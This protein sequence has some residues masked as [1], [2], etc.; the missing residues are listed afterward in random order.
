[1]GES[2]KLVLSILVLAATAFGETPA[3]PADHAEQGLKRK[4]ALAQGVGPTG[5]IEVGDFQDLISPYFFGHYGIAGLQ[6]GEIAATAVAA[7][8]LKAALLAQN[9]QAADMSIAQLGQIFRA[10]PGL[11]NFAR[12]PQ[13]EIPSILAVNAEWAI[14]LG[15]APGCLVKKDGVV[16]V[17]RDANLIPLTGCP[18]GQTTPPAYTPE[19]PLVQ[20]A[21]FLVAQAAQAGNGVVLP[22]NNNAAPNPNAVAQGQGAPVQD[23]QQAAMEQAAAEQKALQEKQAAQQAKV[24]QQQQQQLAQQQRQQQLQQLQQLA[25]AA[26]QAAAG[27]TYNQN[28]MQLEN[29]MRA[30]PLQFPAAQ[31]GGPVAEAPVNPQLAQGF[32]SQVGAAVE[33]SRLSA[34][35]Y[36]AGLNR[37]TAQIIENAGKNIGALA[38]A[39]RSPVFGAAA[40]VGQLTV[41]RAPNVSGRGTI[42]YYTGTMASRLAAPTSFFS[43]TT[44]PVVPTQ[45]QNNVFVNQASPMIAGAVPLTGNRRTAGETP[46]GNAQ[47][48]EVAGAPMGVRAITPNRRLPVRNLS[49]AADPK[50]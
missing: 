28:Q 17:V 14:R 22:N 31:F 8:Q 44:A 19:S 37:Q 18:D 33:N 11:V 42:N 4:E 20:A 46:L 50:I 15:L 27:A 29:P 3:V 24:Q 1:M 39:A 16:D 25:Q 9:L 2:L 5:P 36:L 38:M 35:E 26:G 13:S 45:L 48:A 43:R 21:G 12:S 30:P 49:Q 32:P 47:M 10:I 34:D 7:H 41:R 23:P 6:Q 40:A